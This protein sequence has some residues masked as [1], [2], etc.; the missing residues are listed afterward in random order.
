MIVF[1]SSEFIDKLKWLVNDIPNYYYS[2]AGTWC[3]Y[4]PN[5]EK[6]MMDCV[7]SVKGLLWGFK[8][9]KNK[10]HGGG[11]LGSNGVADFTC[12]GA[13]NYCTDVSTDFSNL[14]AGEYLCMKG[15]KYQHTGIYLG[16]GKVFECTTTWN[17]NKCII[18]DIDSYGNRSYKGI[19]ATRWTYHG[20][21]QYIDYSNIEPTPE[22]IPSSFFPPKGYFSL[23]DVSTNVGKI[24]SFMYRMFPLY[25]NKKALGNYYG[26]YIKASITEFQRRTR[27][28]PDGCVGPITLNKLKEY[29]FKE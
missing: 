12:N 10:P 6:F 25:T 13:L 2:K 29:G 19:K 1:T 11:I 16:N 23:G 14:V 21:L 5:N 9:D 24:A 27:L 20:K 26:P 17:T 4:N 15:T 22:P 3:N 28:E 8:A 18:S 7:V